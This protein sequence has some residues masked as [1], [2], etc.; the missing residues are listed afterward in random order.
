MAGVK[1]LRRK[2]KEFVGTDYER[3]AIQA[4]NDYLMD[5]KQY[6]LEADER[7]ERA[8]K[9]AEE[10]RQKRLKVEKREFEER[11]E[12]LIALLM[13][14]FNV[15]RSQ[16]E[17]DLKDKTREELTAALKTAF[18]CADYAEFQSAL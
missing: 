5:I 3:E 17:S 11:R 10:E 1:E 6:Q 12:Y 15:S 4:Q 14:R 13:F 9:L 8:E 16:A 7:A 2:V 18:A